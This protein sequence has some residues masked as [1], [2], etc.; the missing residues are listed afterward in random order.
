MTLTTPRPRSAKF[1]TWNVNG[2]KTRASALSELFTFQRPQAIGITETRTTQLLQPSDLHIHGAIH[3]IPAHVS[4]PTSP[5]RG[6]IAL[7]SN[8]SI[9]SFISE[10]LPERYDNRNF[11][12]AL[13][14]Q[15][16][17][18]LEIVVTYFS[19]RISTEA[20]T[21]AIT[22]IMT[23]STNQTI[24]M[25]DFNAKHTSWSSKSN[26]KGRALYNLSARFGFRIAVPN[27]PT[28]SNRSTGYSSII[29]LFLTKTTPSLNPTPYI[30]R[31]VWNGSSDHEPIMMDVHYNITYTPQKRITKTALAKFRNQE[32]AK[33]FYEAHIPPL[34]ARLNAARS[35]Q[36]AQ[37][38]F[39]DI[40]DTIIKPWTEIMNRRP[41]TFKPFWNE[42]INK[43]ARK[44]RR[45]YDRIGNTNYPTAKREYKRLRSIVTTMV[46]REKRRLAKQQEMAKHTLPA[47]QLSIAIAAD[48]RRV[49]N[50]DATLQRKGKQLTPSQFTK[51]VTENHS[52]ATPILP[53]HF[54]VSADFRA[55]ISCAITNASRG[56]AI[57][58]DGVHSEMLQTHPELFTELIS[59][60]WS[61]AGRLQTY[62]KQW[63]LALLVPIH[64]K[65]GNQVDPANFR[66]ICLLSHLRKVIETALAAEIASEIQATHNPIRLSLRTKH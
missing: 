31:G 11:Y 15:F 57:G 51:Y 64:K 33:L 16:P 7:I 2:V 8:P 26:P 23:N 66:P 14:V 5:P 3:Q 12:Q 30:P 17:N 32:E 41:R 4:S 18:E 10:V 50:R 56:K 36:Q 21:A 20:F 52:Q 47:T 24:L 37:E 38:T 28:Y 44:R 46:R 9:P 6:G 35:P 53:A 39:S 27:T 60:M 63:R 62:P 25:G 43:I 19:P 22:T 45:W 49:R 61:T 54:K 58:A 40:T 65:K 48:L 59:T 34:I 42:N 29:D 1:S 55:R 13:R